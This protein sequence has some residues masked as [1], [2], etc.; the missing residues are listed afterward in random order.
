[1]WEGVPGMKITRLLFCVKEAAELLSK[2]LGKVINVQ[3]VYYLIRM[4]RLTAI[5]F[6]RQFSKPGLRVFLDLSKLFPNSAPC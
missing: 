6:K 5:R 3:R 1:L 2:A 4:G